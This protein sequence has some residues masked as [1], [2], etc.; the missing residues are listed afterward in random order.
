MKMNKTPILIG[1][2]VLLSFVIIYQ[3]T[4]ILHSSTNFSDENK[5]LKTILKSDYELAKLSIINQKAESHYAEAGYAYE[6]GDYKTVER[7][8][9][10]ARDYYFEVSQ[11]Y[12]KVKAEIIATEIEDKLIDI[13]VE[14][15]EVYIEI[16]N[17]MFEACEHFESAARYYDKYYNTN[18]P[19]S[20]MSYEMGGQEIDMMNEKIRAHDLNVEKYNSLMEEFRVELNKRII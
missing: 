12:K 3:A 15:L 2:I 18:V 4:N 14:S 16:S 9:R 10:L 7:E 20:D 13:S 19:S 11:G 5:V 8:S 17:N 1:V 6:D